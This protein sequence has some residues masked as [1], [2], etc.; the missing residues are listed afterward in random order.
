MAVSKKSS[1]RVTLESCFPEEWVNEQARESGWVRRARK[2][3]PLAFVLGVVLGFAQARERS[4]TGLRRGYELASG[5]TLVR[6]SFYYR[7]TPAL[8]EFFQRLLARAMETLAGPV[9]SLGGLLEGFADLMT[10]DATVVRLHTLLARLYPGCRTNHSPAAA[11]LHVVTSAVSISPHTVR[12]SSERVHEVRTLRLG[13]WVKSRLLL[14]DL[15]YYCFSLFERLTRHGGYFISR[16]KSEANFL[17]VKSN[18]S[19]RGRAR[20]LEGRHLKEVLAGLKRQVLDVQVQVPVWHREY[21]GRRSRVMVEFR[22]VGVLGEDGE[23]RLYLT[24]VPGCRLAAQDVG[25]VYRAR[26][27]VELLFK[28]WKSYYCLEDLPSRKAAIVKALLYAAV[29]T[30]VVSRRFQEEL[31]R[32]GD[33]EWGRLTRE[34]WAV[35]FAEFAKV[36]LPL[37]VSEY[38][39]GRRMGIRRLEEILAYEARDPNK[40]RR[41]M[42]GIL[43]SESMG[44]PRNTDITGKYDPK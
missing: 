43:D 4:I 27:S 3:T 9:R 11:K 24:N 2:V 30:S 10:A 17:I 40:N 38:L 34:R 21:R 33:V 25:R 16:V 37:Y 28:E 35:V 8:V 5:E 19:W 1:L 13:P 23:W 29:L 22:L 36:L 7:F 6:S 42:L 20:E 31:R 14:M 15:G 44:S 18:R 39:T 32:R 12:V 26:W 41:R